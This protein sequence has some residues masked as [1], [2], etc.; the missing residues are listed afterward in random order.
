MGR[1]RSRA[2][3][4]V[5]HGNGTVRSV[6]ERFSEAVREDAPNG[7]PLWFNVAYVS[8]AVCAGPAA[9]AAVIGLLYLTATVMG[10]CFNLF[11]HAG[12]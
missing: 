6:T 2:F 5:M 11:K 3:F 9:I 8:L 7:I 12:G 4:R 1:Q 10:H